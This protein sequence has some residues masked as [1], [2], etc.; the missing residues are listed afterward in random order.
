MKAIVYTKYGLPDV[1]QLVE[2][3]KPVHRDNEVL[4]KVHAA[5][6]NS[7]DWDLL[8]GT[9]FVNRIGG[10]RKPKYPILGADIAG[11]V[12]A[13]GSNVTRFQTGD[14]VFGDISGSGWGGFAEYVCARDDVLARK[15][16]NMTF[17]QAASIPQAG[18]LALQGL[19]YG[20]QIHPGQ[21]VL[22]NGAGG[23][24]CTFALQI[25]KSFGA[26]V[27]GV[28]SAEKLDMLR[29]LGADHVIDY[30]KED[31]TKNGKQYD[32]VLD[33]V[34]NRSIFDYKRVLSPNGV[35]VMI[36]GDIGEVMRGALVGAWISRTSSQTMGLLL[37]KPNAGDLEVLRELIEA[38]HVVPIIDRCY[39]L[40]DAS[41]AVRRL[42]EGRVQ[43]KVV[44][45]M[46]DSP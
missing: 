44:I 17:E 25:A 6:V 32:L 39:A 13:V 36:G 11:R 15:P 40:R 7:W 12:E 3:A 34:V 33:V 18:V 14:E 16:A 20:G 19:R 38:G 2:V 31:F 1:L 9:P 23:G 45:S 5:S 22:L 30:R 4:V 37:H 24:V 43:G 46:E 28:D 10:L 26:E 41:E 21:R 27:T 35:F 8:R 29:S 42:G